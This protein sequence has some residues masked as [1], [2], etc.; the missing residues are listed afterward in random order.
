MDKLRNLNPLHERY[1]YPS[2][3]VFGAVVLLFGLLLR[4][5][6]FLDIINFVLEVLGWVGILGGAALAITGL[7]A[8]GSERGWWDTITGFEG[9]MPPG[10]G[11][12]GSALF[13][14]TLIFFFLPWMSVS[15]FDE[16]F[17]SVSGTDIMGITKADDLPDEL[18]SGDF[19]ISDAL[20]SE[21]VLLYV[22]ATLAIAGG[23][24]FFVP[25][26]KGSYTRAGIAGVGIVCILVFLLLTLSSVASEMGVSIGEL[27]EAGIDVSI[28]FGLWLTLVGFMAAGVVQFVPLLSRNPTQGS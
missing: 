24:L 26:S 22:A 13:L 1:G 3:V 8:Y 9:R 14:L 27:E 25:G 28:K 19:G 11:L 10:R 5:D 15:C 23:A 17:V 7:V 20:A 18:S 2:L 21:A 12:S 4:S 6:L 16:E